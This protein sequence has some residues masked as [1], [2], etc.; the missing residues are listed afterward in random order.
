M[1]PKKMEERKPKVS[2][3]MKAY[4][5]FYRI[6]GITFGGIAFNNEGK[7]YVNKYLTYYGYSTA[8]FITTS[9]IFGFIYAMKSREVT[10]I[11]NS[12]Q[13]IVYLC[14]LLT[15]C[16]QVFHVLVN[17]WYLNRNGIK[18][19]N[20]FYEY[21]MRIKKNQFL[22]F[23]IW[24]LHIVIPIVAH[25]CIL[26]YSKTKTFEPTDPV[27]VLVVITFRIFSFLAFWV[28]SF[29]TWIISI[30]FYEF[31]TD[32]KLAFEQQVNRSAGII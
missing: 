17:L 21:K 28:I 13:V 25:F 12:G 3:I 24:V 9:N 30:H 27:L 11:Y 10:E 18:F 26:Y 15:S 5:W 4:V 22:I 2:P 6:I 20:T 14:G 7:L 19:L 29:L 16:L 32:I 1:L 23:I 8:V 31:L